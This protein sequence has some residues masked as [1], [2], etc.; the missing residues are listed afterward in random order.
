[1]SGPTFKVQARNRAERGTNCASKFKTPS[2]PLLLLLQAILIVG[3]LSKYPSFIGIMETPAV[4]IS[5]S[6][7]AVDAGRRFVVSDG[8]LQAPYHVPHERRK[9]DGDFPLL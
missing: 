7:G 8:I 2:R 4:E 3:I 9:D 5:C 1:V 6:S